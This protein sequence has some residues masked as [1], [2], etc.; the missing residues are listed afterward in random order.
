M[1]EKKPLKL[2]R[3]KWRNKRPRKTWKQELAYLLEVHG[4]E[5]ANTLDGPTRVL[6]YQTKH[7]RGQVLFRCWEVLGQLGTQPRTVKN[8]GERHVQRLVTYWEKAG[9]S[10][11]TIQDYL[12][13]LRTF[14]R[15]IGKPGMVKGASCYLQELEKAVRHCCADQDLSWSAHGVEPAAVID[16]VAEYDPFVTLQLLAMEAFYL[17]PREAIFLR[18]WHADQGHCLLISEGTKGGRAR[19]VSI[20]DMQREVLD[21]LKRA[22]GD[23]KSAHLGKPGLSAEQAIRRFSYVMT[24]FG[25]TRKDKGVTAYGLRHGGANRLFET[26][27][28]TL[29]PVQGGTG[30]GADPLRV[31][32]ARAGVAEALGHSRLQIANAYLGSFKEFLRRMRATQSAHDSE[33]TRDVTAQGAESSVS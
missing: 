14:A 9:L 8:F 22:V 24:R 31:H 17:R 12:T 32:L 11:G 21:A 5:P 6:S 26:L 15:W 13:I 4:R 10:A 33:L 7:L 25:I 18:P 3:K 1:S 23:D 27:A 19:L 20:G 2:S 16:E 28:G 29:S 30:E